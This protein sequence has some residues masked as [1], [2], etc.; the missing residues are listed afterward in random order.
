[1][2]QSPKS[3]YG[4][5]SRKNGRYPTEFGSAILLYGAFIHLNAINLHA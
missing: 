5:E 2:I 1:M 4:S 3:G